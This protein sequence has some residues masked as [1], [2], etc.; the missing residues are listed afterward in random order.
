MI[1]TGLAAQTACIWEAIARK[2][3]NVNR[4]HDF[5]D[6]TFTDFLLS[7]AAIAPI[8]EMASHH[9]VGDTILRSIEA[10]RK[11][12]NTN[13]NLGIVLLLAPMAT[14]TENT[15]L[16]SGISE[17]LESLTVEDAQKAYQAIR[18]AQ[19]GGMGKV[20]EQDIQNDPNQTLRDVMAQAALRDSIALQYANGFQQVFEGTDLLREVLPNGTVEEAILNCY[21]Q[22]LAKYPD[23]L[24]ARKRG[25]V[26]AQEVSRR[27]EKIV[28]SGW[29]PRQGWPPAIQ[30]FDV[31]L[32]DESHS[33]NPGTTADLV[34]ASL[35][36]LLQ[37]GE[38][39]CHH[40]FTAFARN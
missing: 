28:E 30:A 19:P 40:P 8:M 2:P 34:A 33:R 31:W 3:G 22:L 32:R 1:T 18:L 20:H 38:V 4:D 14:I 27:A 26:A 39:E 5:H 10:T 23:T 9:P 6:L 35:F 12:T 15:D 16:Q 37:Q 13:T 17:V 29:Q 11:V 7:A 25:V 36:A 24:I 21:L